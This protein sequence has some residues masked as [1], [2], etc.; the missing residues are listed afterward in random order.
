MRYRHASFPSEE[1]D[2]Q[3]TTKI[4]KIENVPMDYKSAAWFILHR[5]ML[6]TL[7]TL[8]A[9]IMKR[10]DSSKKEIEKKHIGKPVTLSYIYI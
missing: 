1:Y 6:E 2:V 5:Q 4:D 10:K 7:T 8:P 9:S 3:V